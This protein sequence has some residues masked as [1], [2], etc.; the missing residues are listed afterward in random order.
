LTP[1]DLGNLEPLRMAD[2][3]SCLLTAGPGKYILW[4]P[5]ANPIQ[6][7]NPNFLA[8]RLTR[9]GV[10]VGELKLANNPVTDNFGDV[11]T[12]TVGAQWI[13]GQPAPVPLT[14][15]LYAYP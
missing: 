7:V 12:N 9:Q 10:V 11:F 1:Q 4:R 6:M 2:D 5:G 15:A 13:P 8:H 14:T 3:A